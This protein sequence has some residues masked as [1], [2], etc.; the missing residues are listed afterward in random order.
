M[1]ISRTLIGV[2]KGPKHPSEV[3]STSKIKGSVELGSTLWKG[4]MFS[5]KNHI[6]R[7]D[8]VFGA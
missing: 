6:S 1:C 2:T 5:W 7:D 4:K 3:V 8:N